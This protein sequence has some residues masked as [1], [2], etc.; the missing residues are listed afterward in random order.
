MSQQQHKHQSFNLGFSVIPSVLDA[1]DHRLKECRGTLRLD[2]PPDTSLTFT[3]GDQ[4]LN[5]VHSAMRFHARLM[6]LMKTKRSQTE[7][8]KEI[9]ERHLLSANPK[10]LTPDGIVALVAIANDERANCM[11]KLRE[12]FEAAL[13]EFLASE[14]PRWIAFPWPLWGGNSGT[15]STWSL[16]FGCP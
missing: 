13:K 2:M 10:G 11:L 8:S 16:I 12:Q 4:H 15:T 1:S 6:F 14:K 9:L 5:Q 7:A 3:E